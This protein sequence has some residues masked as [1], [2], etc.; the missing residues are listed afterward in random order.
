MFEVKLPLLAWSDN[1]YSKIQLLNGLSEANS[2]NL[3]SSIFILQ[4]SLVPR[5]FV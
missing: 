2:A 1:R 3:Q 4:S 5:V